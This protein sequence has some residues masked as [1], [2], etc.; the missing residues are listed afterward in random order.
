MP[1][2]AT[3]WQVSF[4]VNRMAEGSAEIEVLCDS[5][6]PLLGL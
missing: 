5:V 2:D 1:M 3:S 4:T 6:R